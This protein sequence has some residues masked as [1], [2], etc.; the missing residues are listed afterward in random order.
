ML[1]AVATFLTAVEARYPPH[2]GHSPSHARLYT[3]TAYHIGV[4][5]P[6]EPSG[7]SKCQ[8]RSS[9]TLTSSSPV[10]TL[11]YG[12]EVAGFPTFNVQKLSKPAQ[13][14]LKYS[15]PYDGLSMPYSD[16]PL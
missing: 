3:P 7:F 10:L 12:A 14:E 5:A 6:D 9:F 11:D 8:P 1:A 2:H 16:G 15:E 4:S 13:V